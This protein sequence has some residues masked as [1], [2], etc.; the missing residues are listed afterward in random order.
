MSDTNVLLPPIDMEDERAHRIQI[1]RF[2]RT[3]P[4]ATHAGPS[5]PSV[6]NA[7]RDKF[8]VGDLVW[9]SAPAG[10]QS[11]GWVCVTSG[12]FSAADSADHPT[13]K[14]FGYIVP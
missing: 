6:G 10:G 2:L 13:F 11:I 9:N 5:I 3:V 1:S 14:K 12:D 4:R 7:P 8:A